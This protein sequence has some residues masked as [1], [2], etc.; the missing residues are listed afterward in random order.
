MKTQVIALAA[1]QVKTINKETHMSLRILQFGTGI[2]LRGFWSDLV[3]RMNDSG[4]DL[5]ITSV[6]LTASAEKEPESAF[7]APWTLR[8]RGLVEG[9]EYDAQRLITCNDAYLN[10]FTD[11]ADFLATAHDPEIAVI[12]SNSTEAGIAWFPAPRETA[13]SFPA[14]LCL[15]LEERHRSGLA[16]PLILPF[17]LIEDNGAK[18]RDLVLRHAAEWQM[19]MAFQIWLVEKCDF[20]NTLVDRIVTRDAASAVTAEPYAFLAIDG[21]QREELLPLS[22]CAI[23]F[24]WTD[25]LRPYRQRKVGLLNGGHTALVFPALE[26]GHTT[27]IEAMRD[28]QMRGFLEEL[29]LREIVPALALSS[30]LGG[31][32]LRRYAL[33]V[34]DRFANP[35]LQ[36]QLLA[37]ALNSSSK[38]RV[39]LEPS[40]DAYQ[41]LFGTPPPLISR[42]FDSFRRAVRDG[43]IE[44]DSLHLAGTSPRSFRDDPE[45]LRQLKSQN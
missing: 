8:L 44:G 5:K 22:R 21:A 11:P 18:L 13:T 31:A 32:E 17:E 34:L 20:R 9:R 38:F 2:F 10:P 24:L 15:W 37:I 43:R 25:S 7:T 28:P 36:H 6:K 29:M 19:P 41:Q 23:D 39:R 40:R 12:V 26:A 16:A 1:A 33:G 42:A 27:V 30:G 3:Q 14:R 35:F 45:A 4:A